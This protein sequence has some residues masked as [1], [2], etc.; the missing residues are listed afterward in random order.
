MQARS[1]VA[2]HARLALGAIRR[3]SILFDYGVATDREVVEWADSQIS[4][5]DFKLA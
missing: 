4:A 3:A 2:R 1:E 5:K